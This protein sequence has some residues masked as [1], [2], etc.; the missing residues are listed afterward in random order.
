[1]SDS[2]KDRR[3][4][5]HPLVGCS[6]RAV[7]D[8]DGTGRTVKPPL[9]KLAERT[10]RTE[11]ADG[12]QQ[13]ATDTPGTAELGAAPGELPQTGVLSRP[14]PLTRPDVLRILPHRTSGADIM[15]VLPARAGDRAALVL[16]RQASRSTGLDDIG[17][18]PPSRG[19][20][21]DLSFRYIVRY[22]Q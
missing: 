17:G 13:M 18:R 4:R 22:A 9:A 14:G 20:V 6:R 2:T 3:E 21:K 15:R 11:S 8:A 10:Q 7:P 12:M 19:T 5:R 1:V 16:R